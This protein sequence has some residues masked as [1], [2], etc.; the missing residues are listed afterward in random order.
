MNLRT[1]LW[2][3]HREVRS[4]TFMALYLLCYISVLRYAYLFADDY[5]YLYH[6]TLGTVWPAAI[7][8]IS[9]GRPL[10]A[11]TLL[12]A[13]HLAGHYPAVRWIRAVGVLGIGWLMWLVYRALLRRGWSTPLAFATAFLIGLLPPFQVLAAWAT[14]YIFPWAAALT[15]IAAMMLEREPL[16]RRRYA[17]AIG[18][19]LIAFSVYQP[20]AAFFGV[21]M[22]IRLLTPSETRERII[23][24]FRYTVVFGCAAVLAFVEQRIL[25]S[26]YPVKASNLRA[27]LLT[28][29]V[30]KLF[31]L[32][33]PIFQVLNLDNLAV[34][35]MFGK[36]LGIAV[37]LLIM[38]CGLWFVWRRVSNHR[39]LYVG[40]L[41][42]P[43][44]VSFAPN[45]II[46]ENDSVYRVLMGLS[47]TVV[48]YG[49]F[50]VAQAWTTVKSAPMILF[51][52]GAFPAFL[53]VCVGWTFT[54][55]TQELVL[56]SR[57][58]ITWLQT[59]VAHLPKGDGPLYLVPP[60]TNEPLAPLQMMEFGEVSL[61]K[62]E[63]LP[64]APYD[65][66][67]PRS[68][69]TIISIKPP[70]GAKEVVNL[71]HLLAPK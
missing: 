46:Q 45:L 3:S 16:S 56:P 32:P 29:P 62:G 34:N 44:L 55:T 5:Y 12:G 9:D 50:F 61:S 21:F 41:I 7:S 38:G 17:G 42:I 63:F 69:H 18:L 59:A 40:S 19:L 47:A 15:G 35:T 6:A 43:V 11:A 26:F 14:T 58:Q 48:V 60:P 25:E 30:Q 33:H 1:V 36:G 39:L 10:Y 27:A 31:W 70:V 51:R 65:A 23:Q 71:K 54:Q 49:V 2:N 53:I 52:W 64:V 22:G 8:I 66:G 28:N 67:L 13:F 37:G 24:T 4:T 20:A 57:L 68:V